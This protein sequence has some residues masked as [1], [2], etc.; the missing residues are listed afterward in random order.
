MKDTTA[1]RILSTVLSV[2]LIVCAAGCNGSQSGTT[3][4]DTE[5][6]T[7]KAETTAAAEVTAEAVKATEGT[8]MKVEN[9]SFK[10]RPGDIITFGKYEQDNKKSNGKEDIEWIVL[11]REG[12]KVLVLSR[13]ALASKP[14]NNKKTDVTWE[15]C[16]LRKWLNKDF[17]ESAF[18]EEDKSCIVKTN[19]PADKNPEC[20]TSQGNPTED[21]V[22]L[23]SIAEFNK[24]FASN[25]NVMCDGT[26]S[27]QAQ[28]KTRN[29]TT[30]VWW[31][32]TNGD[33]QRHA[34]CVVYY[35]DGPINTHGIFVDRVKECTSMK[36]L[37]NSGVRPAI[38]LELPDYYTTPH[39]H[40]N[41]WVE[42]YG[43]VRIN[44]EA[45]TSKK[46]E[47]EIPDMPCQIL[48]TDGFPSHGG[49]VRCTNETEKAI[50]EWLNKNVGEDLGYSWYGDDKYGA[51]VVFYSGH[52]EKTK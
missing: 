23:L 38:W 36:E 6:T 29:A 40:L 13:Y 51:G 5:T 49:E 27:C 20:E 4:S 1:K 3:Q 52:L 43:T 44:C 9:Q 45:S 28:D 18:D 11:A 42:G 30:F 10:Y 14:Y 37:G 35:A 21:N 22:F 7:A 39:K 25:K 32:R 47:A 15:T 46:V 31:L 17:Y 26:P 2:S 34:A 16:S 19:V 8:T 33:S 12:N 24:Y 50:L 48:Y 41:A